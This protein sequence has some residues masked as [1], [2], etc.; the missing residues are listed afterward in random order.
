MSESNKTTFHMSKTK[1]MEMMYEILYPTLPYRS[2]EKDYSNSNYSK[3]EICKKCGGQCCRTCGCEF[4]PDDFKEISFEYLKGEMEKGYISITYVDGE[5]VFED[6]GIYI[7]RMRNKDRPVIDLESAPNQCIIWNKDT[8]CPFDYE[9]RPSGGKLLVPTEEVC[10]GLFMDIKKCH[11]DYTMILCCYEWKP[12]QRVLLKLVDYF[13][14][15]DIPC[16]L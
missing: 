16:S 6:F 15:R 4:S 9:H 1:F 3:P 2:V 8:G 12:H 7:L 11:T 10:E 14:D 5:S 13:K